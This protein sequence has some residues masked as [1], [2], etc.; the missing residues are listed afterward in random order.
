MVGHFLPALYSQAPNRQQYIHPFHY[1]L[2]QSAILFGGYSRA[3]GWNGWW[4]TMT[5]EHF[6]TG[7][8]INNCTR[9]TLVIVLLLLLLLL[10]RSSLAQL[11]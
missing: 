1:T 11:T 7:A 6:S 2:M 9:T 4:N 10:K 5:D 8:V 3:F